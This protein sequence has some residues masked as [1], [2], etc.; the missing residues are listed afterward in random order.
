MVAPASFKIVTVLLFGDE[1][2]SIPELSHCRIRY[3]SWKFPG[4][5][6]CLVYNI[7]VGIEHNAIFARYE[8]RINNLCCTARNQD[9]LR[10]G[11]NRRSGRSDSAAGIV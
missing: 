11:T 8:A 7:S 6:R 5:F 9:A 3:R 4:L 10:E 1:K 2:S